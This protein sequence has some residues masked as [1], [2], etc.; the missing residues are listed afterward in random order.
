MFLTHMRLNPGR[1]GT[2][3]L[4]ASAQRMHAAV[5]LGYPGI[6]TDAERV[7]WRI[8]Q[9]S[10]HDVNLLI[11]S[12]REPDLTHVIEQAGWPTSAEA[13]WRTRPYSPFLDRLDAGQRWAFRVRVNPVVRKRDPARGNRIVTIPHLTVA[14]QEQW[15]VDRAE[16]LGVTLTD[17]SEKEPSVHLTHRTT[18]SFERRSAPAGKGRDVTIASAQLDGLLE[19]VDP[20]RL[21]TALTTG[22]GRAKAYGCGLMTLA[23]PRP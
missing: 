3:R 22:I 13:T 5:L 20:V 19:V 9:P 4:L 16:Q 1:R 18:G 15:L 12:P 21:R 14:Q 8:D 11:V 2:S 10:S 6:D 7:L 23:T 17:P